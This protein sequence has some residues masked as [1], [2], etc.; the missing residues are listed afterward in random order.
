M[1]VALCFLSASVQAIGLDRGGKGSVTLLA[2]RQKD[3]ECEDGCSFKPFCLP[4][5]CWEGEECATE[6][7]LCTDDT[8]SSCKTMK[9]ACDRELRTMLCANAKDAVCE[10]RMGVEVFDRQAQA[11]AREQ[12]KEMGETDVYG[13]PIDEDVYEEAKPLNCMSMATPTAEDWC[14]TITCDMDA[15]QCSYARE[16]DCSPGSFDGELPD[17]ASSRVA[18]DI[19]CACAELPDARCVPGS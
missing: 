6:P 5:A 10:Q 13:L 1:P 11:A 19:A 3:M 16:C 18:C 8:W 9:D 14:P 12:A 17:D 15:G 7:V 4:G 2:P